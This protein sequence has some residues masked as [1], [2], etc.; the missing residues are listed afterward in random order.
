MHLP[1]RL[2]DPHCAGISKVR[3][4]VLA[5]LEKIISQK[6]IRHSMVTNNISNEN[7]QS[8]F[9]G[10][11]A[12]TGENMVH[13][14]KW[15]LAKIEALGHI[16]YF[17]IYIGQLRAFLMKVAKLILPLGVQA[18]TV[19]AIFLNTDLSMNTDNYFTKF[20]LPEFPSEFGWKRA[21]WASQMIKKVMEFHQKGLK[22]E[23][24]EE[25]CL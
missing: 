16:F 19:S 13:A 4:P 5:S 12:G 17:G 18:G 20:Y 2:Y 23:I 24:S 10:E 14:L 1:P 11:N 6:I 21:R 3:V 25:N 9:C 22:R 7:L 15:A 8:I